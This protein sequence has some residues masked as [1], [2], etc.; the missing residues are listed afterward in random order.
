MG[1]WSGPGGVLGGTAAK[2][3]LVDHQRRVGAD[4]HARAIGEQELGLAIGI[5]CDKIADKDFRADGKRPLAHGPGRGGR[6]D[7]RHGFAD[8]IARRR[9]GS[10]EREE[11]RRNQR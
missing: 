2:H 8:I 9:R 4:D 7:N 6:V 11:R 10:A 3:E 1:H 5:G